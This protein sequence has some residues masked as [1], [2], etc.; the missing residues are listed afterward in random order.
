MERHH[1]RGKMLVRERIELLV[2]RDSPFL[3]LSPLAAWGTEYLLGAN[4]VTGIGVVEGVECVISANDPT[5][6]GGS[7]NPYSLAKSLRAQDLAR[8]NRMPL[9]NLTESGG[10]DLP[11]QADVFLTGGKW[12]RNL[13][14]LSEMGIPTLA[15]VFGNSTAGGAYVPGMCDYSVM[16]KERAKVFLGGPPLVK[17]ATGEESTDEELGGADMHSRISGL[18]DYY[19]VDE[20]DAIGSDARSSPIST[21]ARRATD[22]PGPRSEPLYDQDEL[23]GVASA[24]LKVPFDMREI[25]ARVVDGSEFD[26]YKQLYGTSLLTGWA[27]I[28]GFPVGVVANQQGVLFSEEAQKATEFIQLCNKQDTPA[29]LHPQH[30]RLHGRARSTN[31][32]ASSRTAPRWSTPSRT[33]RCPTSSF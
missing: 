27:W 29:H 1:Q 5:M 20:Y 8:I 9:I 13:T 28:H 33:R 17:M 10:A 32:A 24:D 19:A 21:G 30:H 6:Q 3:E 18:S 16:V 14:N 25:L 2:D 7:S 23:L 31:S 12:F 11:R 15:L 4:V 22:R 26:E